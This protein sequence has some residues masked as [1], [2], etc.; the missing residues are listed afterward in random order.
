MLFINNMTSKRLEF[1]FN[2]YVCWSPLIFKF[3]LYI[4]IYNF[5]EVLFCYKFGFKFVIFVGLILSFFTT[6]L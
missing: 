6:L 1:F 5:L 4:F 3:I 2:T